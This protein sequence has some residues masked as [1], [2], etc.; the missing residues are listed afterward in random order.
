M[1]K[2]H[3][4]QNIGFSNIHPFITGRIVRKIKKAGGKPYLVDIIEQYQRAILRGYTQEVI[5]C[6]IF[7]NAGLKDEYYVEK[8][9]NFK[10][11]EKLQLG[12]FCK[13]ADVLVDL[14]HFKAHNSVGFGGAIKNLAI[15]CFTRKTRF[16]MHQPY[17]GI[18][19]GMTIDQNAKMK[20]IL[21]SWLNHVHIKL[22]N[23]KMEN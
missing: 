11:L 7:P 16:A 5:G 2:V 9:V 4:G 15:G 22:L 12:G 23:T 17:N 10:G 19:T 14:S 13:D 3:L 8:V 1:I 20:N 21:K 18:N 6:P